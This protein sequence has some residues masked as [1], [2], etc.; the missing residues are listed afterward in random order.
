MGALTLQVKIKMVLLTDFLTEIVV[1][2]LVAF[3]T[4]LLKTK[5]NRK[6]IKNLIALNVVKIIGS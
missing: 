5:Y 6:A 2:G 4:E 3:A 1:P